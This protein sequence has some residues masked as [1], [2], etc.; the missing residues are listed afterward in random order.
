MDQVGAAP[1]Q[2]A[3][4]GPTGGTAGPNRSHFVS[5]AVCPFL[6]VLFHFLPGIHVIVTPGADS[7]FSR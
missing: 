1:G 6:S 7:D 4:M 5:Q 3:G 2:E